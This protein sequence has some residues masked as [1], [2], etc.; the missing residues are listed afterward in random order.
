MMIG[1]EGPS[2]VI[3]SRAGCGADARWALHWRN[4]K[5][6]PVDRVKT[7]LACEDHRGFL[8]DYLDAREFPLVV[9]DIDETIE[10]VPDRTD[11][12]AAPTAVV[13]RPEQTDTSVSSL[14]GQSR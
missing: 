9:T 3:C 8:H 14:T 13:P 1:L 5:I 6:H 10:R 2:E 7:W 4:P 11:A 12:A